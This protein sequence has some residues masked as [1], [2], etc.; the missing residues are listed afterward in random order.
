MT[1]GL[2]APS[3]DFGPSVVL[4]TP[5]VAA[6]KRHCAVGAESKQALQE[7]SEVLPFRLLRELFHS[8]YI[9]RGQLVVA[10]V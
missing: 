9:A 3:M 4:V 5:P 1:G 6:L 8:M 7:N 10:T 2:R